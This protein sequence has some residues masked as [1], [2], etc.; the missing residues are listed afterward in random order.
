MSAAAKE[1]ESSLDTEAPLIKDGW[2]KKK[3][4]RVNVWGDRFF[5][6]RGSTL[7]YYIKAK[8][9]VSKS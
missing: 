4:S 2:L 7:Y 6:L 8:D 3:S 1:K 5:V 9:P